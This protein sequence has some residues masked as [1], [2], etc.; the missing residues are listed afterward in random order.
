MAAC[1]G[2]RDL[3]R[4][5]RDVGRQQP[6]AGDLERQGDGDRAGADTGVD[7]ARAQRQITAEVYR[8]KVRG[9]WLGQIIGNYAGR[10][11]E[12][13]VARGGLTHTIDWA[14]VLATPTWV[15]DDDTCFEYL[16]ADLLGQ[17]AAPGGA[18][19]TQAWTENVPAGSVALASLMS[20]TS[21]GWTSITHWAPRF[22]A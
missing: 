20:Q 19:I 14:G 10:P 4:R 21:T 13:D 12:G 5:Y 1:V 17:A 6:G 18:Q 8:D 3:E 15:G 16:Y 7:D 11:V 2:P 22:S 9:L